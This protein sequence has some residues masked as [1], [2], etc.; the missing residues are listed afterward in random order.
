MISVCHQLI[1]CYPFDKF[2][3]AQGRNLAEIIFIEPKLVFDAPLSVKITFA[4]LS[5]LHGV[6]KHAIFAGVYR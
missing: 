5:V 1:V 3:F 4:T 6:V 2:L